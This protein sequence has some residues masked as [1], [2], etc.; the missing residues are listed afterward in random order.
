MTLVTVAQKYRQQSPLVF[1]LTNT[2]VTNFTANVL[3]AS[4][5]A[6]AMTNLPGEAGP[7]AAVASAVLVN[8]GT[9]S[10]EQLR[11]M[12]EAV[13]GAT[14]AG[15]PWV[16]DPVAVGALPVRTEFARKILAQH[17][18]LIRGN[19]SE[20]LALAGYQSTGRG[21][22]A[23]DTVSAAISAGRELAQNYG[24]VVAISG[25]ADAIIDAT[26]TTLVHSNGIGLT[27]ITGGGCALG[28][29]CAGMLAITDDPFEATIA[30]HGMYGLAAENAL[31]LSRGPGSFASAFL[32]ELSLFAPEELLN[33]RLQEANHA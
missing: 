8:L 27:G 32:D 16:L 1:C 2:V 26:R 10:T 29:V 30:A 19:A 3:L 21:V 20:I 18:T 12:D 25:A 13:R 31:A 5:A 6:P 33:L 22:D 11:A 4:G 17:P 24:S 15:T 9:P 7:F 23:Q 28:A 14:K